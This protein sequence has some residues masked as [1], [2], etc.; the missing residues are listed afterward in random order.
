MLTTGSRLD[1]IGTLRRCLYSEDQRRK[2]TLARLTYITEFATFGCNMSLQAKLQKPVLKSPGLCKIV[3]RLLTDCS[4]NSCQLSC[5]QARSNHCMAG[6][7][8]STF[9]SVTGILNYLL[10]R[11]FLWLGV[12]QFMFWLIFLPV[13]SRLTATEPACTRVALK[14]LALWSELALDGAKCT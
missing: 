10:Y 8:G 9:V 2:T 7:A 13:S 1:T 3:R 14:V 5:G 12:L 11:L 6:P 4:H